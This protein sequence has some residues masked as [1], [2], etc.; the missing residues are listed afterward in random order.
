MARDAQELRRNRPSFFIDIS[1][2]R[3]VDPLVGEVTNLFVFDVDDLEAVVASN[4]RER[5]REAVRAAA[6]VEAEVAEFRK[7]LREIDLGPTIASL[8]GRLHDI[9][10]EEF[11]RRRAGLGGLSAE[12][13]RAV[14]RMLASAVNKVS[15]PLIQC[16]RLSLEAGDE[17]A[18][19]VWRDCFRLE[20]ESEVKASLGGVLADAFGRRAVAA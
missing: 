20:D 1:V 12:Q 14:E 8:K 13:E 16:L 15:H 2:P 5:E 10:G 19:R 9:A 17:E 3:N 6:I 7:S 18:V 11:R 4:L